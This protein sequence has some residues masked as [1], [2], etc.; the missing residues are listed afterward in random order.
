[1]KKKYQ[2]LISG[3]AKLE[4][5]DLEN[6]DE[7]SND[8][9]S[10]NYDMELINAHIR[11]IES[12]RTEESLRQYLSDKSM[13]KDILIRIAKNYNISASKKYNEKTIADKIVNTT[14]GL[15]TRSKAIRNTKLKR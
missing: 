5:V 15:A 13:N 1:M 12:M 7:I 4:F 2:K 11:K 3:K 6:S 14:V 10:E 8:K 9:T